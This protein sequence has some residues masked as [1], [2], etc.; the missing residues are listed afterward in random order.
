MKVLHCRVDSATGAMMYE[1]RASW[2]KV[3]NR[4]KRALLC[5][6]VLSW[7]FRSTPIVIFHRVNCVLV[8][9]TPICPAACLN[10]Q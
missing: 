8:I 7:S 1:R 4:M 3:S 5:K 6:V 9:G 10:D 2:T